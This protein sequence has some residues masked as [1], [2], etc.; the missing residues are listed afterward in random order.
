MK[1]YKSSVWPLTRI[2]SKPPNPNPNRP[3]RS[4]N[5]NRRTRRQ[6]T[7]S[8][9]I[10]SG[11]LRSARWALRSKRVGQLPLTWEPSPV[12]Q[13][14]V[15]LA[16]PM[17]SSTRHCCAMSIT[18]T[19]QTPRQCARRNTLC[20]EWRE[21]NSRCTLS[22]A[23]PGSPVPSPSPHCSWIHL[24]ELQSLL[25]PSPPDNIAPQA[26][27]KVVD[28]TRGSQKDKIAGFTLTPRPTQ[29]PNLLAKP[30]RFS[31]L[32]QPTTFTPIRLTQEHCGGSRCASPTSL[33][34]IS[35][36]WH[37]PICQPVKKRTTWPSTL[38]KKV[39]WSSQLTCHY[40]VPAST[41]QA[42]ASRTSSFPSWTWPEAWP[43]RFRSSA[44]F[45]I[46]VLRSSNQY[47]APLGGPRRR[48]STCFAVASMK[49]RLETLSL[50]RIPSQS[51][52]LVISAFSSSLPPILVP[53][54][55]P[56][57]VISAFSSSLPPILEEPP[58]ELQ[59]Q[60]QRPA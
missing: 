48:T 38:T 15:S 28:S 37:W 13:T 3:S 5:P 22:W 57:L 58:A 16:S 49:P 60:D 6:W 14:T 34:I 45:L 46:Q 17:S 30:L 40:L 1:K 9:M 23:H 21:S 59:V 32:V 2:R 18:R 53:S 42:Q 27:G 36:T 24:Q 12:R 44:P 31:H 35:P 55:S 4:Q 50:C 47:S 56:Q 54:Q 10:E 7:R 29:V 11:S 51:P 26:S 33:P 39:T 25:T 41:P 8:K 20:I 19:P 52:Q 43:L